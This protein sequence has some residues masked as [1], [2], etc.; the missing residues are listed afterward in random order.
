MGGGRGSGFVPQSHNC[1]FEG[2]CLVFVCEEKGGEK[3]SGPAPWPLVCGSPGILRCHR[4]SVVSMS[5]MGLIGGGGGAT[6]ERKGTRE[7]VR[8]IAN[9]LGGLRDYLFII[10]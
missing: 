7:D 5:S 1:I 6:E 4:A 10:N 2:L 9:D 3:G 8:S